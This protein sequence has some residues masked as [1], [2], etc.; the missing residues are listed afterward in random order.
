LSVNNAYYQVYFGNVTSNNKYIINI[1][2]SDGLVDTG[3]YHNTENKVN[4]DINLFSFG[5]WQ[6]INITATIKV[7]DSSNILLVEYII[8]Y[9]D[10]PFA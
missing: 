8:A 6:D 2:T 10:I 3:N 5:N 4:E 1:T 7:Y 9:K